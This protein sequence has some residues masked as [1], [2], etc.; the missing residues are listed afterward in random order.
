MTTFPSD[1]LA[2]VPT[3]SSTYFNPALPAEK[4]FQS[5][6]PI[7]VRARLRAMTDQIFNFEER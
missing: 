2:P 7:I 1:G 3:T 6:T 4:Y 5:V